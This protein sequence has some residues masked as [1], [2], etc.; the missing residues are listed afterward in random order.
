MQ[1][2]VATIGAAK[3]LKGEVRLTVRTDSPEVRFQVGNTLE[4]D[5]AENG[6]LT[7]ARTRS[8]KGG[9]FVQFAEC[10]DRTAAE[11]LRGTDLV[12]ETNEEE[13]E[14][15]AYYE[16]ELVG[17][18]ALDPE[19]YTLG[20]VSGLEFGAAQ[21][22]LVV[23]EPDGKIARVPFV[24][25]IV[26]DVDIADN[27]VVIDAPPGLFSEDE[28]EIEPPDASESNA[29]YMNAGEDA[30]RGGAAASPQ[31]EIRTRPSEER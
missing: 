16:S 31:H 19:G 17:L 1:V 3:G 28:L 23:R 15:D 5:P 27:C 2:V 4:T 18:E 26:T 21:D 20:T 9:L 11:S 8:Y 29:Q 22:I 6:P 24:K 14:E 10:R 12:V 30:A 13:P 7:I 25:A